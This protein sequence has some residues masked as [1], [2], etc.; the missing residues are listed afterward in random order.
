M[1]KAGQKYEQQKPVKVHPVKDGRRVP[2]KQLMKKLDVYKYETKTP[3]VKDFPEPSQVKILLKQHVGNPAKPIVKIGDKV[4]AG[5][6]IADIEA[7]KLGAKVH[8]SIS[9]KIIDVSEEFIKIS[10]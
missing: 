7:N 10:K 1:K 4:Q 3:F 8:A 6:L 9:G 5:D 2:L